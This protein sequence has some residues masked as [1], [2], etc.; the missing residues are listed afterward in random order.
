MGIHP[1]TIEAIGR[2]L[3]YL[4]TINQKEE[5]LV[6]LAL[7]ENMALSQANPKLNT[8]YNK[9]TSLAE[10]LQIS[11]QASSTT[12]HGLKNTQ[13]ALNPS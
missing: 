1:I 2:S 5:K 8:W 12:K 6:F 3:K 13:K 11:T 7:Q 10:A 4:N 9:I